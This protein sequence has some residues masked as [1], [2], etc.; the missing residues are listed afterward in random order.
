MQDFSIAIGRS[1]QRLRK[2]NI[3]IGPRESEG[4]DRLAMVF[5]NMDQYLVQDDEN[6]TACLK[7]PEGSSWWF[8]YDSETEANAYYLKLLARTDPKGEK[9]SRLAKYL[10]N[11]RK[12]AHLLEQPPR[13]GHCHRGIADYCRKPAAR[14]RP[15]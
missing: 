5:R 6:Q 7:L 8:W 11:N 3:W 14:S 2:G 4:P 10:L 15:R 13:H 9:T 1:F 12:H